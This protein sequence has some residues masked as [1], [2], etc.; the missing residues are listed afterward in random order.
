MLTRPLTLVATLLTAL[1]VSGSGRTPGKVEPAP[2]ADAPK[3][4]AAARP[5]G[6]VRD[7][8]ADVDGKLTAR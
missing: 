3:P 2:A 1:A 4:V 7:R 5:A 8:L 6:W